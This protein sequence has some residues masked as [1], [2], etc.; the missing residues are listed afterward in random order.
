MGISIL[1]PPLSRSILR[2]DR[3]RCAAITLRYLRRAPLVDGEEC[4]PEPV[5][6]APAPS[7]AEAEDHIALK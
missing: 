4:E 3:A 1:E 6:V 2:C 7:R 5:A